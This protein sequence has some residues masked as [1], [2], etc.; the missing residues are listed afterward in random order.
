[1]LFAVFVGRW[2]HGRCLDDRLLAPGPANRAA[3][4][5][6]LL[7]LL[8]RSGSG[9]LWRRRMLFAFDGGRRSDSRNRRLEA[10]VGVFAIATIAMRIA[11]IRALITLATAIATFTL[12]IMTFAI[13]IV[14]T[15]IIAIAAFAART[16][17]L[18]V[19]VAAIVAIATVTAEV[20]PVLPV[21]A[22]STIE[23][24][25]IATIVPVM[26]VVIVT[27]M[28]RRTIVVA[29]LVIIE[30]ARRLLL[31]G[32]LRVGLIALAHDL[33]L[34]T[35]T[36]FVAFLVAE[37]VVDALRACKRVRPRC[38]IAHRVHAA[39]LRHLLT[40]AEDD[41]IVVLSVLKVV[42]GEHRIARRQRIACQ[43]DVF[44]RDVRRRAANL[45]VRPRALEA[46]HQGILRFA[47]IV[48]VSSATATVLLTLP[49]GLPFMLVGITT[50]VRQ[51]CKATPKDP[52][53]QFK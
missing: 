8:D 46:P 40:I 17:P 29:V 34:L 24:L 10:A 19:T 28:P 21:T 41:A 42:F 35:A 37:F 13:A 51:S 2:W 50:G 14:R 52:S 36:E 45:Y 9:S 7:L 3:Q 26:T 44:F 22:I 16:V 11:A 32:L 31:E 30:V 25:T 4:E 5:G 48:V 23:A 47:V 18:L 15:A 6:W 38:A 43:R 33:R 1:L 39:L 49:H 27:L 20:L 53:I 12:L